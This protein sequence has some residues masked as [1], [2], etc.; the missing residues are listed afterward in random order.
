MTTQRDSFH[1]EAKSIR[2]EMSRLLQGLD[3]HLD[4]KPNE[5]EWSAREIVY[6]M[7]ETPA[8]GIHT[9]I[10]RV[11]EGSIQELPILANLTNVT[12]ERQAKDMEKVRADVEVVLTGMERVLAST[13][14]AEL[15]DKKVVYHS[16]LRSMKEDRTAEVLTAGYF[17]RHWK[18]HMGQLAKLR[19]ALGVG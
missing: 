12:Q 18:D 10:Q 5:D 14:D 11:L 8:E 6:H 16:V 9:A 19:E 3:D 7:V 4:W 13:T 2:G 17:V 1:E 15:A